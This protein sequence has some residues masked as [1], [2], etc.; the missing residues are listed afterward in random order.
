[1]R[2]SM[3]RQA[4]IAVCATGMNVPSAAL[5]KR[6]VP[7]LGAGTCVFGNVASSW[8]RIIRN[9][10]Q[11]LLVFTPYLTS[12]K[13]L[14]AAAPTVRMRIYTEFSAELFASGASSLAA[15]KEMAKRRN[16]EVYWLPGLHAKIIV[17]DNRCFSLGSQN[18]TAKGERNIEATTLITNSAAADGALKVLETW[19][20]WAAPITPQM[21]S[22]MES[23]VPPLIKLHQSFKKAC[24]QT[25]REIMTM[26]KMA[27]QR[28][29]EA[30]RVAQ[31]E[32][33][34]AFLQEIAAAER[35]SSEL[36]QAVQSQI[37][38]SL[39]TFK[40]YSSAGRIDERIS[41]RFIDKSAWWLDHP[42][43]HPVRMPLHARDHVR[44]SR[45]YGHAWTFTGD[46]N[47]KFLLDEAIKS[48]MNH[49]E[50]VFREGV[51]SK[52]LSS[53]QDVIQALVQ[54]IIR[55]VA[56]KNGRRYLELY[57]GVH[58]H[59][60]KFGVHAINAQDFA[61]FFLKIFCGGA[62]F[63]VQL[64]EMRKTDQLLGEDYNTQ[65]NDDFSDEE[66]FDEE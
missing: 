42:S 52:R 34:R 13:V 48:C 29:Q 27:D 50:S 43:G 7:V 39:E 56:K 4:R 41:K 8:A 66:M 32:E 51:S 54:L 10:K 53:Y 49:M 35:K 55:C 57:G 44:C 59:Q 31:S 65:E 46:S 58:G 16:T 30:Q 28:R 23:L 25:G 17:V 60:I 45:T 12:L 6:E 14:R 18:V 37:R 40:V 20:S 33:N 19:Q 24:A 64:A 22:H 5:R 26:I 47:N 62:A 36:F 9:A 63:F 11:Q 3:S 15:V 38:E 21:I 2:T 61:E 1:M